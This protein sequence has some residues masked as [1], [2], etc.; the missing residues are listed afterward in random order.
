MVGCG[1]V[2]HPANLSVTLSAQTEEE[3]QVLAAYDQLGLQGLGCRVR[4]FQEPLS[5]TLNPKP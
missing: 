3:P 4:E 2:G 5:L 1:R